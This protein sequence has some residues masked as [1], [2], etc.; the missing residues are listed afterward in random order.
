[1]PERRVRVTLMVR[2]HTGL[3]R[4]LAVL[5]QDLGRSRLNA[6]LSSHSTTSASRPCFALQKSFASTA[7]PDR[8]GV[9]KRTTSTTPLIARAF[10]SSTR[11]TLPP[12]RGA[13][14]TTAVSIPGSLMSCV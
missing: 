2:D 13:W 14:A 5:G 4:K 11:P 9:S 1:M 10:V 7:T 6:V 12:K 8:T 3:R